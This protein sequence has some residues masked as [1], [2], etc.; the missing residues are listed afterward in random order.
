MTSLAFL[1]KRDQPELLQEMIDSGISAILIKV[2][3]LGLMPEKHLG[4]TLSEMKPHLIK[5]QD[6]FGTEILITF[7]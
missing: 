2:A 5:L 4:K 3:C 6:E 7:N 1:W